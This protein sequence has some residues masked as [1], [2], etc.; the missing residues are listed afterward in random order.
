MIERRGPIDASVTVLLLHGR[1]RDASDVLGLA[2]RMGLD[3]VAFVKISESVVAL[4]LFSAS[5]AL[6]VSNR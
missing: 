6:M 3:D 1:G 5:L 4:K 2:D